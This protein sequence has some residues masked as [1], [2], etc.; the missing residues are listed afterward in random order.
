MLVPIFDS[1]A[2]RLRF[3]L[4]SPLDDAVV[5]D[6]ADENIDA[7]VG[8][9]IRETRV[10]VGIRVRNHDRL[11]VTARSKLRISPAQ[12]PDEVIALTGVRS[13]ERRVGKECRSRWSPYH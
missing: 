9:E 12:E 7:V 5:I 8:K 6:R 2:E 3:L 11:E 10:V 1:W 4:R 13:E